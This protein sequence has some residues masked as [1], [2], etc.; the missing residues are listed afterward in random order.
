MAK[1]KPKTDLVPLDGPAQTK[2]QSQKKFLAA[3]AN[4]GVIRQAAAAAE[5]HRNTH[6][7]WMTTD[8]TY[9]PRFAAAQN[10]ANDFLESVARQRATIGWLEPVFYEGVE[11]GYK[12]RFSDRMLELLMRHNN[13]AKFGERP[14]DAPTVNVLNV[15]NADD[16]RA[17]LSAIATRLG[18]ANVVDAAPAE[19]TNGHSNGNGSAGNGHRTNG[20]DE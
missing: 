20:A 12:Q 2:K 19:N 17:R 18:L 3:Y 10:D 1:R 6:Q 13:P 7:K 8:P 9:P 4:L 16:Q 14:A 5:I 15:I 11:C